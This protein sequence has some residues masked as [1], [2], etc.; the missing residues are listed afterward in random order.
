MYSSSIMIPVALL[1]VVNVALVQSK[2]QHGVD[3]CIP[4]PCGP[5]T[6][7]SVN[8]AG[9]AICRCISGTYPKPDTITGCGPQ[10]VYDHECPSHQKC[11]QGK[12][13]PSC[14]PSPCGINAECEAVGNKAVCKCPRGFAGDPLFQCQ[15]QAPISR[16]IISQP[17]PQAI[18]AHDPCNPSP[19]GTNAEC[20]SSGG[21]IG[22]AIC[23]CPRGH[24]GNPQTFCRRGECS[25]NDECPSFQVCE[26]YNCVNPC[27]KACGT[28]AQC[29]VRNHIATCSCPAGWTGEPTTHCRRYNPNEL[30]EPS[31]CGR[32]TNCRVENNRAICSCKATFIGDPISGCR[33]ECDSDY[34]CGSGQACKD[35][36]CKN[37]CVNACGTYASCEVNNHRAV[38]TCPKDYLGD[39]YTRCFP[40]CTSHADCPANRACIGLRCGDPCEN[41]CGVNAECRVDKNNHKAICSCPK[42]WTGH[43]FQQCR[44]Q[45]PEDLC[46]P[47]PCGT[48]AICT[49]GHDNTG[50]DRPV[51]TCPSGYFGNALMNCRRGECASDSEC[52]S[53]RI[54]SNFNC[55]DPC[56]GACGTNAK[57]EAR[58][59]GA[60]CSCLTGWRGDPFFQCSFDPVR[61]KRKVS[62]NDEAEEIAK[63]DK[64]VE[65][66]TAEE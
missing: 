47:N 3:P 39:P 34:D 37:P 32:N 18:R 9:A 14:N 44:R 16:A 28:N 11:H 5:N 36:K 59:H 19:C 61:A 63:L 50:S 56:I 13:V 52:S 65:L 66:P 29:D 25:S 64:E 24:F 30:C 15:Q 62:D 23:T 58:N 42:G 27:S 49:P 21:D 8:G 2:A 53:N 4:S 48:N 46:H 17:P 54:C 10:C 12:C 33:H 60:V 26:D 55:V 31:P 38:C 57:C 7:C 40:E 45:T 43:P 6:Q 41:A 1:F 22:R 51:C 20:R 35:F